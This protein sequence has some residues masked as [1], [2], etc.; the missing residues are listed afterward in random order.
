MFHI[1]PV[2]PIG[3]IRGRLCRGFRHCGGYHA[4]RIEDEDEYERAIANR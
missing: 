1:S 3:L 2:G 4:P